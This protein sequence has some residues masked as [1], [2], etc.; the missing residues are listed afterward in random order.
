[1][2]FQPRISHILA[3]YFALAAFG[4]AYNKIIAKLERTGL[5]EGFTWLAV[6]VGT[7]AVLIGLAF[8]DWQFTLIAVGAFAVA[9]MPMVGGAIARYIIIRKEIQDSLRRFNE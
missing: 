4:F 7:S 5:L 3:V 8:L 2:D 6:V 9:G 1:M